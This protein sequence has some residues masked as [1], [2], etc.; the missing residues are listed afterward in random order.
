MVF[1]DFCKYC[2]KIVKWDEDKDLTRAFRYKDDYYCSLKCVKAVHEK[3]K[4]FL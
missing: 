1:V 2:D 3:R 4:K